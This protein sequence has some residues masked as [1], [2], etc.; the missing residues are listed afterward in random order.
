[1]SDIQL[2]EIWVNNLGVQLTYRTFHFSVYNVK[3]V[4]NNVRQDDII[5]LISN[6]H[7]KKM[8]AEIVPQGDF[9]VKMV[10]LL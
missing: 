5:C 7:W 8:G 10:R 4:I 9:L 6:T 2:V 1:M 3:R